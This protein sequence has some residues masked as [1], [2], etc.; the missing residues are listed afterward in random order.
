VDGATTADSLCL[1]P[2]TAALPVVDAC[3]T[4]APLHT[5][6]IVFFIQVTFDEMMSAG[7]RWLEMKKFAEAATCFKQSE[8][9]AVSILREL[10]P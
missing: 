9:L 1:L 4:H 6:S 10:E 8:A 7:E 5:C 3:H 2:D